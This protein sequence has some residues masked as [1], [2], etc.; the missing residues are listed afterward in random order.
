MEARDAYRL[1]QQIDP[2]NLCEVVRAYQNTAI[3]ELERLVATYPDIPV[4]Y[5]Y[6]SVAYFNTGD[7]ERAEALV[8][9][10]YRRHPTYLFAKT[11][12]AQFCLRR[13]EIEKIP[14]L[15][16]HQFD[17]KMLYPQRKRFHI[18][19][20]V[21]FAGV[22]CRYFNAIGEREI[23]ILFYQSLKRVAPRNRVTALAKR[24]L[25]PP[26]WVKWLRKWV[27]KRIDEEPNN[28]KRIDHT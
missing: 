1:S 24:T 17:L 7:L 18:T 10:T 2:E 8:L 25:Y 3:P 13:G 26:F 21:N 15:F 6:L 16:N 11:N 5:N 23:A 20:F 28:P 27:G 14:V 9:E 22:M 4:F 12:Y 19:E